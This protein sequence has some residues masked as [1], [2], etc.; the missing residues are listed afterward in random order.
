M[1]V[2]QT[3]GVALLCALSALLLR[4]SKSS[5]A[6]LLPITG[7]L[8]LLLLALPRLSAF[9]SFFSLLEQN[10]LGEDCALVARILSVGLVTALGADAC[11]ELGAPSLATKVELVGKIEILVLALPTLTALLEAAMAL[12]S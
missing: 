10:G 4:E 6:P 11:G 12:L 7:G 8:L 5:L 9:S 3:V 1:S 2:G